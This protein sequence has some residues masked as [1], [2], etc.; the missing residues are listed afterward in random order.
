[1]KNKKLYCFIE[2]SILKAKYDKSLRLVEEDD[3]DYRDGFEHDRDRI[4]YSKAF[5]RLSGKIQVF[6]SGFDDHIRTRLTHTIE[7]NQIAKTTG[8]KLGLNIDLIEAIA[9]GHDIGHTPFGHIGERT[10]N[11]IL[12]GCIDVKG[13]N[14]IAK[15]KSNKGFKHNFQGIK[16]V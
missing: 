3:D 1:M 13:F 7:V 10:L 2:E 14:R 4:L 6:V 9:L 15:S 5:R 8:K 12:N 11:L 16:I